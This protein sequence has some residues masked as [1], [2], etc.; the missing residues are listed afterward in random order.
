MTPTGLEVLKASKLSTPGSSISF[1]ALGSTV[2]VPRHDDFVM[3]QLFQRA[4]EGLQG[5]RVGKV[6]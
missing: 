5:L 3:V 4:L 2:A 6:R 1:I